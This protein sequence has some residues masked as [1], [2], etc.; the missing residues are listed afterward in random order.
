MQYVSVL[1]CGCTGVWGIGVAT[2][3]C[4]VNAVPLGTDAQSW[5]LRHDGVLAHNNEQK[6]QL[7]EAPN[8]GDVIVSILCHAFQSLQSYAY[9]LPFTL[10]TS[11]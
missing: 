6:A 9:C 3:N 7:G 4:N 11:L 10:S 8:E 1:V 2:R 5:V